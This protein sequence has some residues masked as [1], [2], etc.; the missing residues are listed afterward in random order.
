M[1]NDEHAWPVRSR[2]RT[3]IKI[4]SLWSCTVIG[5]LMPPIADRWG[6]FPGILI[7]L[8]VA[9]PLVIASLRFPAGRPARWYDVALALAVLG[10]VAGGSY[11][12]RAE[13][14]S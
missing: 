11:L 8:G 7:G 12:L 6:L 1:K 5:A 10:V 14:T 13:W 9:G 4:R 3:P 2:L